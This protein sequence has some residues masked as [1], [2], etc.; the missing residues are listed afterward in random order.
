MNK[1][2]NQ[3]ATPTEQRQEQERQTNEALL[4]EDAVQTTAYLANA[5]DCCSGAEQLDHVLGMLGSLYGI[6]KKHGR[7]AFLDA[8]KDY[9]A[10]VRDTVEDTLAEMESR[11]YDGGHTMTEAEKMVDD[12]NHGLTALNTQQYAEPVMAQPEMR[13]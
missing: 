7:D 2:Q 10:H 3:L 9:S 11:W 13:M 12:Y 6:Y 1:K 8:A 4:A 5:P